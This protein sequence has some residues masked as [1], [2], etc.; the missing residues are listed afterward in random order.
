MS[1]S[2]FSLQDRRV[3]KG[4]FSLAAADSVGLSDEV[5]YLVEDRQAAG[6]SDRPSVN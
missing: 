2:V 5:C 4:L 1:A 3:M 6:R